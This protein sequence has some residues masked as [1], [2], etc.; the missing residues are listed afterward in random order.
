MKN[1]RTIR[2]R[3][4]SLFCICT[5]ALATSTCAAGEPT[6]A[7]YTYEAEVTEHEI[8]SITDS[9]YHAINSGLVLFGKDEVW[10]QE[11]GSTSE[12]WRTPLNT[13]CED[14]R[15]VKHNKSNYIYFWCADEDEDGGTKD[16]KVF[17]VDLIS[18][19][20]IEFFDYKD[21]EK[22]AGAS[23]WTGNMR[24]ATVDQFSAYLYKEEYQE[25]TDPS[26]DGEA[27]IAV[28]KADTPNSPAAL[29]S[30]T[31]S[32]EELRNNPAFITG[33]FVQ[34]NGQTYDLRGQ[35]PKQLSSFIASNNLDAAK[36]C[37]ILFSDE[38]FLVWL[39]AE[40]GKTVADAWMLD[41]SGNEIMH[42]ANPS[43]F[44]E[45][46]I[47]SFYTN[48]AAENPDPFQSADSRG[49][50]TAEGAYWKI[51]FESGEATEIIPASDS[52]PW[53]SGSKYDNDNESL[54]YIYEAAPEGN[55]I[56]YKFYDFTSGEPMFE[57]AYP[58]TGNQDDYSGSVDE[59]DG[60]ELIYIENNGKITGYT[61]TGE[62]M[63]SFDTPEGSDSCYSTITGWFCYSTNP[64]TSRLEPGYNWVTVSKTLNK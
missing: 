3:L 10:F 16:F 64:E 15:V 30:V 49:F 62:E 25:E 44:N 35:Q 55:E 37:T 20:T 56:V 53:I 21:L 8:P 13:S 29:L 17:Q 51:N 43:F 11:Y 1:S 23:N 39:I 9:N 5:L 59:F 28:Y 22:I 42:Y 61:A 7:D 26:K 48:T 40:G 32:K 6:A 52:A 54:Y 63:V 14:I 4:S 60:D 38:R 57:V 19:K 31:A 46:N 18:A 50:F 12:K 33:D 36:V 24:V 41:I 34:F 45:L 2:A 27:T 47:N 58:Y